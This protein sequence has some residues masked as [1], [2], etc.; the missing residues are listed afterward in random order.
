M[1]LVKVT[2]V[3]D[4]IVMQR[5]TILTFELEFA[6]FT[7][8]K[9]RIALGKKSKKKEAAARRNVMKEMIDDAWVW[10]IRLF[11]LATADVQFAGRMRTRKRRNGKRNNF[12]G[13][14]G[15]VLNLLKQ[16]NRNANIGQHPV[17]RPDAF[18]IPGSNTTNFHTVP[19]PSA[20]PTLDAAIQRLTNS[21]SQL[22]AS[23]AMNTSSMTK[24][25]DEQTILDEKGKDMRSMVVNAETKRSWF[26][27]FRDWVETVA[28]F[29]DEKARS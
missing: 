19:Q 21:M 8:A 1:I 18:P 14:H 27:S 29:L 4:T 24:L 12:E 23:H 2:M 17:R 13:Q 9:E 22:V 11:F 25:A 10:F 6:E 5:V 28:A 26:S 20:L 16:G 7:S 3:S 15:K